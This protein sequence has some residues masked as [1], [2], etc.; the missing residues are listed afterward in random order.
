MAAIWNSDSTMAGRLSTPR[1][2]YTAPPMSQQRLGQ[3]RP[4]PRSASNLSMNSDHVL[5]DFGVPDRSH[6]TQISSV[7]SGACQTHWGRSNNYETPDHVESESPTGA[8]NT[9][10]PVETNL[11]YGVSAST[12]HDRAASPRLMTRH[13]QV[14]GIS[15]TVGEAP[16][17]NLLEASGGRPNRHSVPA[18]K[19]R[20]H[21]NADGLT[22]SR[23]QACRSAHKTRSSSLS[24]AIQRDRG[25]PPQVSFS[26]NTNRT[27]SAFGR[28]PPSRHDLP[29]NSRTTVHTSLA[30]PQPRTAPKRPSLAPR[31]TKTT[32]PLLSVDLSET[33]SHGDFESQ[34]RRVYSRAASSL[35]SPAPSDE[36]VFSWSSRSATH[37]PVP[38]DMQTTED[39]STPINIPQSPQL[40]SCVARNALSSPPPSPARAH[41]QKAYNRKERF[42]V[43]VEETDEDSANTSQSGALNDS[44]G[45]VDIGRSKLGLLLKVDDT[46]TRPLLSP[47]PFSAS[48]DLDRFL[49]SSA[50]RF[51]TPHMPDLNDRPAKQI[52]AQDA[53]N[54]ELFARILPKVLRDRRSYRKF[55]AFRDD[56]A[57][58]ILDSIQL[59]A[60]VAAGMEYLH[61]NQ[62]VHGDIKGANILVS[63]TGR[64]CLTDFGLA[65]IA[66]AHGVQPPAFSSSG[67][68]RF[69]APELIDPN[70]ENP[71]SKPSD[72]YAFAMTCY[73][74]IFRSL[75]LDVITSWRPARKAKRFNLRGGWTLKHY[76]EPGAR[77]LAATSKQ[78]AKRVT[79][80][81][82]VV[83]FY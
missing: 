15:S 66:E 49:V 28:S 29:A 20:N 69:Q 82:K 19:A 44:A 11:Y 48:A 60:G 81:S 35:P 65:S 72:V 75:K 51:T 46:D 9:D 43:F 62:V 31:P 55:L 37:T 26:V 12:K 36:I 53:K 6:S 45:V 80:C 3:Q 21:S 27:R 7:L 38:A 74:D 79:D 22:H 25:P 54:Y 4:L 73:Q 83:R 58:H 50:A 39:H 56:D 16:L 63:D 30:H 76:V 71:R 78:T 14:G 8:T 33:E 24:P 47:P 10:P 2:T 32:Q 61:N 23:E 17:K 13:L 41:H 68:A 64:A 1:P 59:I 57:Q 40:S 5:L 42:E 18:S 77:L 34:H 52:S 67:T 70:T